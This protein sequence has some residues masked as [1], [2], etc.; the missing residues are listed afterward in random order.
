MKLYI[1]TPIN[2]RNENT[3]QDKFQAAKKRCDNLKRI[4][5]N[6]AL[7]QQFT[8]IKTP[9]DM[10]GNGKHITEE[11]ALAAC[12]YEVLTCDAIYL[13][14]GWEN[15]RGCTLEYHTAKIYKKEI[16]EHS[17]MDFVKQRNITLQFFFI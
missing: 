15:S 3:F 1:S 7:L 14:E 12:I 11:E 6:N 4:I 10:Y 5:S 16:I 13:D 9:F 8:T 17:R 2:A